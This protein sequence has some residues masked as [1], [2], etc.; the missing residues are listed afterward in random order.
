MFNVIP[1][2]D[3]QMTKLAGALTIGKY[4]PGT[5]G[6]L[7]DVSFVT[8]SDVPEDM[9]TVTT[10]VASSEH[11]KAEI[12]TQNV[13]L[14]GELQIVVTP[15]EGYRLDSLTVNGKDYAAYSGVQ[16]QYEGEK[17]TV[18]FPSWTANKAEIAAVFDE[19]DYI[20]P[21]GT[22]AKNGTVTVSD[23]I[24]VGD[25]LVISLAPD[26][27]YIFSSLTINDKDY[28]E[29]E[30]AELVYDGENVTVTAPW[31]RRGCWRCWPTPPTWSARAIPAARAAW[32]TPLTC[33]SRA[34]RSA[35]SLPPSPPTWT[36]C[37][38]SS[39]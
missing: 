30:G 25:D 22:T 38:R 37:S 29:Y 34:A 33:C 13:A 9:M 3:S 32:A 28:S 20:E 11:G 8:G 21:S 10:S 19:V 39:M 24:P 36:G 15:D 18:T 35:S 12:V 2:Y 23:R 14:G 1:G 31:A 26:D 6:T 4:A 27:G 16:T 5:R 17:V 7:L